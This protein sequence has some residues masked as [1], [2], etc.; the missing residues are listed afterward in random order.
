MSQN[1]KFLYLNFNLTVLSSAKVTNSCNTVPSQP[2]YSNL[3]FSQEVI[4]TSVH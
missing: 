4:Q 1:L 3:M 2:H